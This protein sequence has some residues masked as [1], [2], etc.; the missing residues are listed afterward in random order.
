MTWFKREY[1]LIS[2]D[3]LT[4]STELTLIIQ[5]LALVAVYLHVNQ[6]HVDVE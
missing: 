4:P 1:Y 6:Q 3:S 2:A 5:S